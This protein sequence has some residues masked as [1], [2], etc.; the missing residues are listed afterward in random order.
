MGI[1]QDKTWRKKVYLLV[2]PCL[3]ILLCAQLRWPARVLGQDGNTVSWSTR[4]RVWCANHP[5]HQDCLWTLRVSAGH[6]ATGTVCTAK[7]P[8]MHA[9]TLRHTNTFPLTLCSFS[10]PAQFNERVSQIC[11]PPERYIVAEG[12]NC[13]IAGWGE[14]KGKYT[15]L[16][17]ITWYWL[18]YMLCFIQLQY[19]SIAIINNRWLPQNVHL[20]FALE[21]M[22]HLKKR[23]KAIQAVEQQ[24]ALLFPEAFN[25]CPPSSSFLHLSK[26]ISC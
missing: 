21:V 4:R 12:T 16:E 1:F 2:F 8:N 26:H 15:P 6:A 11:L 22:S 3:L 9:H 13:E 7:C 25:I 17:V 18:H 20:V 24:M 19:A 5:S 23:P 10:S 14:T